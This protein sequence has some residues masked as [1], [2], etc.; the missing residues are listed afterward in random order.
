M[1]DSTL[2]YTEP[3]QAQIISSHKNVGPL[4]GLHSMLLP[5]VVH[6]TVCRRAVRLLVVLFYAFAQYLLQF[7]NQ[8]KLHFCS[9]T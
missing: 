1:G 6:Q 9:V 7:N 5:E 8:F 2:I 4:C 3:C